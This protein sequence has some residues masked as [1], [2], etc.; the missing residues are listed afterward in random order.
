MDKSKYADIY[1]RIEIDLRRTGKGLNKLGISPR[2][3]RNINKDEE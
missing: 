1:I 3:K 2:M